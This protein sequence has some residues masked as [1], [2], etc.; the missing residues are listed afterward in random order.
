MAL[1]GAINRE[2][3]A[4]IIR[5]SIMLTTSVAAMVIFIKSFID[6]GKRAKVNNY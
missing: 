6:A 5:V 3:T 2:S 4:G 1:R